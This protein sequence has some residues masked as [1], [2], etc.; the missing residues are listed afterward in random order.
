MLVLLVPVVLESGIE[1][2]YLY[3]SFSFLASN[4]TSSTSA[5]PHTCP[6]QPNLQPP[7][8]LSLP[9][10]SLAPEDG[11]EL[12]FLGTG[13]AIPSKY[14][15]VSSLFLD[16]YHRGTMLI[17]CGEG[18]L[19]Q[20]IRRYGREKALEHVANLKLIWISHFHADHHGGLYEVLRVSVV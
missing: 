1:R 9:L 5:T 11:F 12:T 4:L 14:R 7:L 17:D 19:S 18:S 2:G 13:A 8:F 16:L 3:N 15:N 10:Q 20:M 6:S